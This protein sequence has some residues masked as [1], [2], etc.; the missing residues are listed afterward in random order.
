MPEKSGGKSD[1]KRLYT[2]SAFSVTGVPKKFFGCQLP[3]NMALC[4]RRAT[5]T[6][7]SSPLTSRDGCTSARR[8][9]YEKRRQG[10][11]NAAFGIRNA[12][13]AG[14]AEQSGGAVPGARHGGA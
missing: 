10:K 1:R 14:A 13:E 4:A 2:L 7:R 5:G 3:G 9:G 6:Q 12:L 11:Q 8:T